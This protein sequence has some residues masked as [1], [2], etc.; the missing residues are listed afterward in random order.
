MA[1]YCELAE[2]IDPK[3]YKQLLIPGTRI[4]EGSYYD[5]DHPDP[6]AASY[7]EHLLKL[8]GINGETIVKRVDGPLPEGLSEE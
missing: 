5:A 4:I 8:N 2:E 7:A 1:P 6:A 3:L